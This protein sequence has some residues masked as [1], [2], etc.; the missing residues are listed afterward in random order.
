VP[1]GYKHSLCFVEVGFLLKHSLISCGKECDIAL[2][3]FARDRINIILGWHLL[4]FKPEYASFMY[5]P[6]QLEQL[7]PD[8][9]RAFS[10]DVIQT[11][12]HAHDVWDYSPENVRFLGGQG[13]RA[14]HLPIGFHPS[15][16]QIPANRPK[17]ID[18]LFFGSIGERRQK[19][20]TDLNGKKLKLHAL[21]GVYG[22]ERDE[23][24]ARSKIILNIHF[25]S[26]KI[27]EAVRISYLLNNR[28]FIISE[29][30]EVNPYPKIDLKMVAYEELAEA[31]CS[32]LSDTRAIENIM[33]ANFEQF[34]KN[35]PMTD[36][37]REIIASMPVGAVVPS[38][39]SR[40]D[41]S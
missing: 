31:C 22:K 6:Y 4:P 11:L 39:L 14:R 33:N 37:V 9:W 10:P 36:M 7:S 15:L 27:F 19:V 38:F 25:Y 21:F 18:V 40:S 13:I 20:L 29:E 5:I 24:I 16:E 3:D 41:P 35:Y 32:A 17:D 23:Y 1:P 12:L 34:K 28:C 30:S 2:N 8:M 26:T